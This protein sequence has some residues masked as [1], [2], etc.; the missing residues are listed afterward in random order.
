MQNGAWQSLGLVS[1]PLSK[2]PCARLCAKHI[3]CPHSQ[4]HL[5]WSKVVDRGGSPGPGTTP[6]LGNQ[7]PLGSKARPPVNKEKQP[8]DKPWKRATLCSQR[9]C[10]VGVS[11]HEWRFFQGHLLLTKVREITGLVC[12]GAS[13]CLPHRNSL[14]PQNQKSSSSPLYRRRN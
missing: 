10:P 4:G 7:R 6:M 11:C 9:P 2:W 5:L 1:L 8:G 12:A 13:P 14:E 3:T